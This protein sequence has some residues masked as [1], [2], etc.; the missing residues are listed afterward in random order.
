MLMLGWWSMLLWPPIVAAA[1]A[2]Q[3]V[4]DREEDGEEVDV[5]DYSDIVV[6][7]AFNGSYLSG[8]DYRGL[9]FNEHNEPSKCPHKVGHDKEIWHIYQIIFTSIRYYSVANDQTWCF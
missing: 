2:A 8:K 1:A 3:M 5:I 4:D 7:D 6:F 9:L